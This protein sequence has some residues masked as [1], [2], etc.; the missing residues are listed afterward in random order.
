MRTLCNCHNQLFIRAYIYVCSIVFFFTLRSH[1]Q[2][3]DHY[4]TWTLGGGGG[5]GGGGGCHRAL[6]VHCQFGVGG[7]ELGWRLRMGQGGGGEGSCKGL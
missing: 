4:G 6:Y 5:G 2:I 7:V 3:A 1:N